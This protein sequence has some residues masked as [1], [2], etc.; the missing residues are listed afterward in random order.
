MRETTMCVKSEILCSACLIGYLD[1][2]NMGI[3][4]N[5]LAELKQ[6][7]K[8]IRTNEEIIQ[9]MGIMKW[10]TSYRKCRE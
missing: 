7:N 2:W 5:E 9:I 3:E 6:Q 10:I 8:K 1:V 4:A